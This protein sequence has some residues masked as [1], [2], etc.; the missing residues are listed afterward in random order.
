MGR[1]RRRPRRPTLLDRVRENRTQRKAVP[2]FPNYTQIP[3]LLSIRAWWVVRA[4]GV[5]ATLVVVVLCVAVAKTGLRIVWGIGIPLLP[6]LFFIAPGLWRNICPLAASNQTPRVWG[7]TRAL[8]G[9]GWLKRYGYLI[10]I[11][12]FVAFKTLRKV[13]LRP[14]DPGGNDTTATLF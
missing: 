13:G 5:V 1:E 8:G 2:A 10:S 4:T 3:S 12:L 11:S 14:A 9:A 6:I 7:W